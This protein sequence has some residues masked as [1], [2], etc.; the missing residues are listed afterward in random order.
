MPELV[1][2]PTFDKV[3]DEQRKIPAFV[4]RPEGPGPH[5]VV[6]S[7]HGGP[8]GQARPTFSS[9]YQLW[10]DRLGAAVV[11]PNVRGSSGYGKT[12]L[13]LD[14][15]FGARIRCATSA[16]CWTGSPNSQSSTRTALPSTAA[17]MAATWCWPA[18][19][20]T[21]I[22]CRPQWISSGSAIS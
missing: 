4:Y 13:Q 11:V 1:E 3:G 5:P 2:Y 15:G 9:T 10:I 16:H 19:C 22:D 7:I 6:I 14:N 8:E 17:A 21:A 12:Y 18:R 20:I